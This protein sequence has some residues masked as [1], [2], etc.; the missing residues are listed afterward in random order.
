MSDRVE[1]RYPRRFVNA[2]GIAWRNIDYLEILTQGSPYHGF[3][4]EGDKLVQTFIGSSSFETEQDAED[5]VKKGLWLE[6]FDHHDR[7]D[8]VVQHFEERRSIVFLKSLVKQLREE[9]EQERAK[10]AEQRLGETE[11]HKMLVKAVFGTAA[12]RRGVKR[13]LARRGL[14]GA[15]DREES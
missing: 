9:L 12:D 1:K 15:H 3:K 14:G 2:S 7:N 6:T 11:A 4:K 8:P 13:E 10:Q 5:Q